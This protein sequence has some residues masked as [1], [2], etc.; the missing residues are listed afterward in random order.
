MPG[1]FVFAFAKVE[2][3]REKLYLQSYFPLLLLLKQQF[4]L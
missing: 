3:E 2:N 4:S 1:F